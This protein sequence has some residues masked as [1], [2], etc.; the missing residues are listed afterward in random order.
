MAHDNIN[1][2]LVA[3]AVRAE[4]DH[5]A[6]PEV[7]QKVL[8][9]LFLQLRSTTSPEDG[10][11]TPEA[12]ALAARILSAQ[13][14]FSGHPDKEST[15]RALSPSPQ[16]RGIFKGEELLRQFNK[17]VLNT[18]WNARLLAIKKNRELYPT[19]AELRA[20]I[21]DEVF[22]PDIVD[23]FLSALTQGDSET[24]AAAVRDVKVRSYLLK[25]VLGEQSPSDLFSK[26][27]DGDPASVRILIFLFLE[28]V[29]M[30]NP[31]CFAYRDNDDKFRKFTQENPRFQLEVF[32]WKYSNGG[33]SLAE[34]ASHS[35]NKF[36]AQHIKL[37]FKVKS[38][39]TY[40]ALLSLAVI[41]VQINRVD[42]LANGN[43][44][45][46]IEMAKRNKIF[47]DVM[48]IYAQKSRSAFT[49]DHITKLASLHTQYPNDI[50]YLIWNIL[51][52]RPALRSA[53]HAA[54]LGMNQLD[55]Q[56]KASLKPLKDSVRLQPHATEDPAEQS[57]PPISDA[58]KLGEALDRE[59][60]RRRNEK[61]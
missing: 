23:H 16:T 7:N 14:A 13:S 55:E 46:L 25:E 53:A 1:W 37:L 32:R 31:E 11:V 40:R 24:L 19:E 50:K 43:I 15:L 58:A 17:M 61:K 52:S 29:L 21:L 38:E 5:P 39:E 12:R 54:I 27:S 2:R 26:A 10:V 59:S 57:T 20:A 8:T 28:N 3:S 47:L 49:T 18:T 9:E 60:E 45:R 48:T 22:M 30:E 4:I 6:T 44:D 51:G 41:G 35:P 36:T 42:R 33:K 56:R 34:I